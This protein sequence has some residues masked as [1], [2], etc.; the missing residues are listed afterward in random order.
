MVTPAGSEDLPTPKQAAALAVLAIGD[1]SIEGHPTTADH[2]GIVHHATAQAL[3]AK[4][5]AESYEAGRIDRRWMLRITLAGRTALS[6]MSEDFGQMGQ[7]CDECSP[8]WPH[9]GWLRVCSCDCH[10]ADL[11]HAMAVIEH[12]QGEN[13][14]LRDALG[15]ILA[16]LTDALGDPMGARPSQVTTLYSVASR[17]MRPIQSGSKAEEDDS[18]G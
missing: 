10:P 6:G 13:K 14:R 4:G 9:R 15:V 18:D 8:C 7:T 5:W 17:A 11:E 12:L 1:A 2:G 16:G 3:E